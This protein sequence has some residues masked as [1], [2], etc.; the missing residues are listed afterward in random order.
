MAVLIVVEN[1][2]HWPLDIPGTEIV[3]AREYLTDPRF[4]RMG[5]AKVFNLCRT[6]G[7]QTIGYY[8]SLLAAA[9]GHKPLPSVETVQGLRQA[10]LLRLAAED[11]E[12]LFQRALGPIKADHFELSVY[13]GRNLAK[14]YD[15]LARALF[16]HF[17]APLLRAQFV[18]TDEWRLTSLR[19]IGWNDI[20]ESHH[21][22]VVQQAQA[23]F[24]RPR[25]DGPSRPKYELAIL[26]NRDEVDRPS[27]ERAIRRFVRAAAGLGM[28][29][30]VIDRS[31]YG[32]LGEYDALF[33]RETTGVEHHTYRFACRAEAEGLVVID[34]P[35]SILRCTNK[36]YQAELFA[37]HHIP[38]PKTVVVHR[39][40]AATVGQELGF[41]TVLKKPDSSFSAGVMKAKDEA[42]LATLLT[43]LF[44]T[45]DLVVAQQF[46]RSEFDWRIGVLDG[47]ALFA[48]KY[49]MARGHWQVQ[50]A[51][52][53]KRRSYGRVET[54]AVDDAPPQAIEVALRASAFIGNGLYG[55]DLKETADG[56]VVMEINDNPNIESGSEDAVLKNDLYE[57]VMRCFLERIER[58]RNGGGVR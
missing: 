33:I 8:V 17:P 6:Y 51:H 25:I 10:A 29:A 2:K 4:T 16:N 48:C 44:E 50:K 23:F 53:E 18:R 54:L 5:R 14:R 42:E 19:P 20:P 58:R 13:F 30:S 34:D 1:P 35:T 39:D 47:K 3:R 56:F 7:Y 11:V 15:R 32:R 45:S 52:D 40:N 26:F 57:H 55:V 41:P 31:E 22:F 28:R 38:C 49:F 24:A 12:E 36:V 46:V 43:T 27:D 37:K 9:R 21:E